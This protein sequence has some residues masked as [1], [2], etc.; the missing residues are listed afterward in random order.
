[1]HLQRVL[2]DVLVPWLVREQVGFAELVQDGLVN[3]QVSAW[4]LELGVACECAAGE[5]VCVRRPKD[6]DVLRLAEVETFVGPG[7]A[8][9]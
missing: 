6:E 1:M 2:A 4:C 8:G 7:R 5:A 9:T 3:C